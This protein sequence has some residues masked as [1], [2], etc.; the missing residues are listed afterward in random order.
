MKTMTAVI[1]APNASAETIALRIC[2]DLLI[3]GHDAIAQP[4]I[5]MAIATVNPRVAARISTLDTV[6]TI[7]FI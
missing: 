5:S 3:N 7:S 2:G 1:T 4:I 6:D